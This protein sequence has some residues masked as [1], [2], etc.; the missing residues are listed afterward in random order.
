MRTP[1]IRSARD[2][3]CYHPAMAANETSLFL[4]GMPRDVIRLA[5]AEAARRGVTLGRVVAEAPSKDGTGP[6]FRTVFI[7][8]LLPSADITLG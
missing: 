3:A 1:S 5:K 8:S 2:N 7:F 6:Q 4:R